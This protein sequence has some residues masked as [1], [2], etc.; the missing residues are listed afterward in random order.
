MLPALAARACGYMEATRLAV[1]L[2][3][4]TG[5]RL[6]H[7]KALSLGPLSLHGKTQSNK[8]VRNLLQGQEVVAEPAER[9][10]ILSSKEAC[11]WVL[12]SPLPGFR[13]SFRLRALVF[14]PGLAQH[15]CEF[16]RE[17]AGRALA[18]CGE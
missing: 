3:K 18:G 17:N 9:S 4:K 14:A 2:G 11:P 1:L 15:F 8:G 5:I 13:L 16:Y 7:E 10:P 6:L 12:S